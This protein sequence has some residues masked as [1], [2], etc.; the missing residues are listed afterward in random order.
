[1]PL[2][3]RLLATTATALA[4]AALAAPNGAVAAV[5]V[6]RGATPIPDG[7]A[8]AP[9]DLT[10]RNDELAFSLAIESQAPWGIPRGAI[11]DLAP[12]KDGE[13]DLDRIAFA[14]FI[15]NN[16]SAWPTT[17]QR[18]EIVKDT[19]E[20]VVIRGERD[21]GEVTVETLYTLQ[22]GSD[23][24]HMVTTMTNEGGEALPD[25]RSGLTLWPDSGYLFAVPGLAGVEDGPADEALAD[26]VVAY[27]EGWTIALHAPYF[28]NVNYGSKDLYL[29]HTLEPGESRSVEG[30][31]QVGASGDLAPVVQAEIER[32]GMPSG[33]LAGSVSTRT[34]QEVSQPVVVVEKEGKPYAWTLG[35]N[36]SYALELPAGEYS[37][38]ATA[39]GHSQGAPINVSV[40]SD[41][42]AT[43]DFADLEAP[44]ELRFRV[45]EAEGGEP[46][47]A[48]IS[49][50]EG[51]TP[52]V[53]YLGRKTFFTELDAVGEAEVTIAPGDYL[54]TVAHGG[55]F[56]GAGE[57]VALTVEPDA[58]QEVEVALDLPFDP[59]ESGWYA[60]DMHHHAD[61]LEGVTPPADVARAELAAGLDVLFLSDHDSTVN[62]HILQEIADRRG[63]V[64]IPSMEFSPSWGHFNAYPL[65]L[66]EPLQ[67][68]TSTASA[69]EV[70][71]E[72]RRLGADAIQV[73][74]PFIPYGYFASLDGGVAPGG[75]DPDF[76]LLEINGAGPEDDPKVL[77][78]IWGLWDKGH[79]YYL[80]AGSDAHDVWNDTTG[81]ARAYVHVPGELTADSFV[82]N[83]KNGRAYVTYGPLIMPDHMFGEEV[84]VEPGEEV[85]LGFD[86]KSV[87]GLKQV[88]LISGGEVV[89]TQEFEAE[90]QE[91][92]AE[93]PVTIE[94]DA[95][96]SVVVEDAVGNM[97]YSNPIWFDAVTYE[98]TA[99]AE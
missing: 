55:G 93:F 87:N 79:R 74:H 51:Q 76:D 5:S 96:Y 18:V 83:L 67:I 81:V 30:W 66:G 32:G 61:Q 12:V 99:S 95:W 26:R 53:E 45:T 28:D 43:Q 34:G 85:A 80:S 48:R 77:E 91:G 37:V 10:V 46:V 19:P 71:A 49:I 11:V 1:M 92:R 15:P 57:E 21:W 98:A 78:K 35:S 47:D 31:L 97:A 50:A 25:L 3:A 73:N 38:Y 86:V 24:V 7:E 52:L 13:I 2:T 88:Q 39:K 65:D 20:E 70:L 89:Q 44:G 94:D 56:L 27:D 84:K 6:V 8:T 22:D 29:T 33:R 54:L 72:A 4:L 36:G 23:R 42:A 63:V 68:D 69:S 60:S 90:S 16:W 17:Y 82:R 59:N 75:F 41:S 14:D 62:Q 40:S 9:G 64:F 58:S